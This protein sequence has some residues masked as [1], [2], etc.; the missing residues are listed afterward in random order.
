[1]AA[2]LKPLHD[3]VIIEKEEELGK[4]KSGI[5]LPDNAKEKSQTGKVI[6]VGGGRVLD[7]GTKVTPEVKAGDKVFYSKYSG[8]EIKIDDHEYIILSESDVLAIVNEK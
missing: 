3:K 6:A 5:V 2:K 1:M 8:T 7:N 4:T